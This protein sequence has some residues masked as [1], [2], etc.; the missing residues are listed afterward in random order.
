MPAI[1]LAIG[2]IATSIGAAFAAG[3]FFTTFLGR[4]LLSVALSALQAALMP[5]GRA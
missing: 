3:G 1:G 2:A 5:K 4:L